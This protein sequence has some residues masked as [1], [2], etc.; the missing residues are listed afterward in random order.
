VTYLAINLMLA[1]VWT[2]LAGSFTVGSLIFG[3]LVGFLVLAAAQPFLPSRSYVKGTW[4]LLRFLSVY[5]YELVVANVQLA[6]DLLR[7]TMPFKPGFI[8]YD[9]S[10]L[11]ATETVVLGNMISLTPGTVTVD[12]GE[13]GRVLY[14]HT[15]YAQDPE[16]LR[17]GITLFADLIDGVTGHEPPPPGDR[18]DRTWKPS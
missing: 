1:I 11:S 14:I 13:E 18:N 5:A 16:K 12:T 8:R 10:Q 2:F 6:R 17:R 4:G 7:P 3:F 15:V 9:S